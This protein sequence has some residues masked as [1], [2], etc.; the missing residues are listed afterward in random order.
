M[1]NGNLLA[2][3][4]IALMVCMLPF[5]VCAQNNNTNKNKKNQKTE[6]RVN[7]MDVIYEDD[8][9]EDV[10]IDQRTKEERSK[11]NTP[12]LLAPP[13]V[14]YEEADGSIQ[15][16]LQEN[17]D[18]GAENENEILMAGFDSAM[19]HY[20]KK[21]FEPGEEV[22]LLLTD[23]QHHFAY[24]T[25]IEA[26]ATS[27]FGPR[28]RRF[29]YGVDLAQPT[30]KDI[31]AMFDGVV[32]ISKYNKSYGNLV[33]IRHDNGLETY[34]AHMSV[35]YA[36]VGKRVK[37]G[38]VIGLCG[39][40]GRSYGSHLHLEIR[41]MG[42][43]MNPE[44]VIN[45][46]D[47]TLINNELVLTQNSFRKVAT[48]T[49]TAQQGGT[50]ARSGGSSGAQYYKVKG[51]DTLSKIAKRNGTTVRRLCQLNGIKETT[52]LSVGRRLRIR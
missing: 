18:E 14:K 41:Y 9:F 24:P 8:D 22:R 17:E 25:P 1:N 40:T 11:P 34:Y 43:A 47:H 45:C 31:Y 15:L 12:H 6:V 30:G 26:R 51:G 46:T 10:I 32:R 38:E 52:I 19:I 35:R 36:R 4:C 49:G 13:P 48:H 20:P 16:P 27:H 7:Q 44:H 21:V 2:K 37:A 5:A 28:R 50:P 29:H 42:N 3:G 39:N 23:A 33:I